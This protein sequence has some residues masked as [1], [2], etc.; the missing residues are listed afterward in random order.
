MKHLFNPLALVLSAMLA[1]IPALHAGITIDMVYVGDAGNPADQAYG[2]NPAF[3]S[4]GYG[5]AIGKYEV[6][7]F[8]YAA[9]LNAVAAVEDTYS[10]YPATNNPSQA[11]NAKNILHPLTRG[12]VQSAVA[13]GFSYSVAAN[14]SDKPANFVTWFSAARFVNWMANGQL[15]GGQTGLTTENGAYTL[16]GTMSGGLSGN[17]TITRNLVNPNTSEA[18]AFWLPSEDE[19]YKAAYY[20]PGSVVETGTG[21]WLY[22]TGN[23]TIPVVA[24]ATATGEIANP[25]EN[26]ANYASGST[27]NGQAENLTTVGSAGALSA[28]YYGTS[29]QAGN[30][31]EWSEGIEKSATARG[32]RQ[33]SANDPAGAPFYL[34]A[35]FG[36]NG[37]PP[38]EYYWNAGFRIAAIPE[39]SAAALL[40]LAVI[41]CLLARKFFASA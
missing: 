2:T 17:T 8:E 3:G 34:A 4:V 14:M 16:N 20:D 9:F 36:N 39:P 21:Y 26:V 6:T 29:D 28:S 38:D 22:A 15:V 13:G 5:F 41:A 18:T 24:T 32:L 1:G 35:S 33:G 19:W 11:G 23:N 27:W 30:V 7:N 25:G 12:I 37:R 40:A 31:W 10:L